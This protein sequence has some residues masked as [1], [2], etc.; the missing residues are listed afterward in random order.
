M[1]YY[2]ILYFK[3]VF[4]MFQVIYNHINSL[5]KDKQHFFIQRYKLKR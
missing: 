1:N 3:F 4:N 2:S 5:L